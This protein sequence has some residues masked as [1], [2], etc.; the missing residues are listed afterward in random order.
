MLYTAI[1]VNNSDNDCYLFKR[2]LIKVIERV[3]Y[4]TCHVNMCLFNKQVIR[5]VKFLC[6]KTEPKDCI[7]KDDYNTC[8]HL[9]LLPAPIFSGIH[10]SPQLEQ[11]HSNTDDC[12]H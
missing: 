4:H 1:V 6:R 12:S 8:S 11:Q 7:I 3:F 9:H 2:L 10:P 5:S